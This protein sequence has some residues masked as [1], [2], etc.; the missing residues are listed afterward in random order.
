MKKG[1]I[2]FLTL[3][4]VAGVVF[5]QSTQRFTRGTYTVTVPSAKYD[6]DAQVCTTNGTITIDVTFNATRMTG[7]E[8]KEATDTAAFLNRATRVMIDA[9]IAAQSAE[10]DIVTGATFSSNALKAAIAEA[11]TKARS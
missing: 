8:V 1:I 3:V 11:I 2:I 10:V 6:Y 7:I 5:A 9:M 4:L